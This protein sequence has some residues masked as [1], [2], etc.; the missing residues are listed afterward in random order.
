MN[1]VGENLVVEQQ[2]TMQSVDQEE[3]EFE[4]EPE[5]LPE[6]VVRKS[7]RIRKQ[8]QFFTAIAETGE[9]MEPTTIEE[10]LNSTD[11]IE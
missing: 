8:T 9:N 3:S 2:P 7:S 11:A 4:Y 6:Q 10:A 1:E 5:F